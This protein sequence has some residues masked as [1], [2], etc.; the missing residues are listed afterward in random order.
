MVLFVL[1]IDVLYV[2]G[3]YSCMESGCWQRIN[4]FMNFDCCR[5][6]FKCNGTMF[7]YWKRGWADSNFPF[8]SIIFTAL[9]RLL[10]ILI[11][12]FFSA[13]PPAVPVR[14]H[15]F[16][17]VFQFL[18]LPWYLSFKY[19]FSNWGYYQSRHLNILQNLFAEVSHL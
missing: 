12:C 11:K 6:I 10:S 13:P 8:K 4:F 16:S 1:L 18:C 19:V 14:S 9:L 2:M 3:R 17:T 15:A 7:R 5:L